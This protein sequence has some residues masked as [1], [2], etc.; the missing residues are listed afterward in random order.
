[1]LAASCARLG[2]DAMRLNLDLT[3]EPS[4]RAK[5]LNVV[6]RE[7]KRAGMFPKNVLR[8]QHFG[9]EGAARVLPACQSDSASTLVS[10]IGPPMPD[11]LRRRFMPG[12]RYDR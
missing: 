10:G 3:A 1:L 9:G 4:E 12:K 2:I 8:G 6:C 11:M 5:F 7:A